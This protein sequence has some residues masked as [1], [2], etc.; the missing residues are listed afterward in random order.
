MLAYISKVILNSSKLKKEIASKDIN[1]KKKTKTILP[2]SLIY[3]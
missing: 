2:H 3:Y 1:A